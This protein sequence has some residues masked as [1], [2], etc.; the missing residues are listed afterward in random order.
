MWR[1]VIM[2][3]MSEYNKPLF[4]SGAVVKLVQKRGPGGVSQI[5]APNTES[6]P[7]SHLH[8]LIQ[9]KQIEKLKLVFLWVL[10]S[11]VTRLVET[12]EHL[13]LAIVAEIRQKTRA[14]KSHTLT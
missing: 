6:H 7:R 9:S 1:I 14:H 10:E 5:S 12:H 8:R 3:L 4:C 2:L 13:I 11:F